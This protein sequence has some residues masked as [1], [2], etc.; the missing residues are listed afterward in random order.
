MCIFSFFFSLLVFLPFLRTI[1][2]LRYCFSTTVFDN[3]LV[4]S[5]F[6]RGVLRFT[7]SLLGLDPNLRA[8][9]HEEVQSLNLDPSIQGG[10]IIQIPIPLDPASLFAG[11][12][13]QRGAAGAAGRG[14]GGGAAGDQSAYDDV[15]LTYSQVGSP[16]IPQPSL[17]SLSSPTQHPPPI[18]KPQSP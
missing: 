5:Y 10:Q 15:Q 16:S 18:T 4:L 7:E 12:G 3:L 9:Y 8:P 6:A 14:S 13:Q 11:G 1:M 2:I 17:R